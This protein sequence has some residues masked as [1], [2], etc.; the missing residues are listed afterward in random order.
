MPSNQS[1]LDETTRLQQETQAAIERMQERVASSQAVGAETVGRLADQNQQLRNTHAATMDLEDKLKE[2]ERLQKKMGR[3]SWNFGAHRAAQKQ[4]QR[5]TKERQRQA[6]AMEKVEEEERPKTGLASKSSII[7]TRKKKQDPIL[8]SSKGSKS[9]GQ[10][11]SKD[12]AQQL[13]NIQS[14]DGVI[15]Q[16]LDALGSQLDTLLE[17]GQMA[18]Q[19][20]KQSRPL[21]DDIQKQ[22]EINDEKQRAA[23][24]RTKRFLGFRN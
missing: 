20:V 14:T 6:K 5:E 7:K 10:A 3:W 22:T 23:T 24:Y 21:M 11:M 4:A 13:E 19:E 15:D 9:K 2:T 18:G 16:G 12:E 1:A 17:V 8:S